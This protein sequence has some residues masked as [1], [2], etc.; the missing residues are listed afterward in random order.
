M[1]EESDFIESFRM[2][3]DCYDIYVKHSGHN[4]DSERVSALV[5]FL[6][7]KIEQQLAK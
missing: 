6:H 7:R 5:C 1:F 3:K 2:L 4:D